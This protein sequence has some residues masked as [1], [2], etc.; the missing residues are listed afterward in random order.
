MRRIIFYTTI[1]FISLASGGLHAQDRF[2]ILEAKLNQL[3]EEN[4]GLY[5]KVDLS[6][7]MVSIQDFIRGIAITDSL[8]ISVDPALSIQIINNFSNV[9]VKDVFMF[10]CKKYDLDIGF[11]GSILSFTKYNSPHEIVKYVPKDVD[12]TYDKS[13]DLLSMDLKSDSLTQVTEKLTEITGKN[14]VYSPDLSRKVLNAY[15]KQMPLKDAIDKLAFAN[16][17]KI[18]ATDDNAYLIEKKEE[19]VSNF[20]NGNTNYKGGQ[21]IDQGG[22]SGLSV[23]KI[24][25]NLVFVDA[26]NAPI[27]KII[28]AVSATLKK[29]Y[30]LY[31][32]VKGNATLTITGGTYDEVLSY[33]LNAT[34]YTYKNDEGI[35]VIGNRNQEGLRATKLFQFKFRTEDKVIDAIP[36]DLKKDIELK[37]YPDL[38]SLIM[39]GSQPRIAELESFLKD[40]D[41]VVPVVIIEVIIA[42]VSNT[43]ALSTGISAGLGT[44]PTTTSGTIFP[45]LNVSLGA[46]AINSV[47][48]SINGLG[49]VNLGNVTPNFYLTLN[50]LDQQGIIKLRSTP[51]LTTLNGHEASMSI[52][53]TDYYLE[54]QNTVVGTQNPQNI[55]TQQYKSIN[56]DLSVKINPIVSGDEQITMDITVKQSEF[57]ARLTPTAPP[58]STTRDFQ[59]VIRVKNGDMVIL[60]GLEENDVNETGSG[61][62][63]LS[64]IPILKWFF[65]SR[66]K[67]SSKER[68]TIFIRPTVIY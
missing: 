55:T 32:D 41:K 16:A 40:I 46:G 27:S 43:K 34:D 25:D 56:A 20:N 59:S 13:G 31:S 12:A 9:M 8:N 53:T 36:S 24:S 54:T 37:S 17:I 38:N 22:A 3:G 57:T 51:K 39:S 58:G 15:I 6:V 68:L 52:G 33:I 63:F 19:V 18:T 10:L 4:P 45:N 28:A 48:N 5:A 14:F 60:G 47:I 29:N 62:P 66:S 23:K 50:A 44:A 67:S 2:A 21:A 30:F 49:I 11:T 7:N 26:V 42:D 61:V 1:F 64:R 35:Y 65:S